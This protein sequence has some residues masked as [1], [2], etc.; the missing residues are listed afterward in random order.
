MS[1]VV[2]KPCMGFGSSRYPISDSTNHLTPDASNLM[3]KMN[4][5]ANEQTYVGDG[6]GFYWFFFFS[7]SL[8]L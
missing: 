3:R 2:A 5:T 7:Y 8:K 1:E 4:Y 6:T